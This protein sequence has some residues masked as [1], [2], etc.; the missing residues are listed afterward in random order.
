MD[1][2]PSLVDN[3]T[4]VDGVFFPD[5]SEDQPTP[6][7]A[8]TVPRK[9]LADDKDLVK[10]VTDHL[11]PIFT[12]YENDR[13]ELD[14]IRHVAHWMKACGQDETVR[15]TERT[16]LDRQSS[17]KTKTITQKCGS[18]LFFR[19][20]RSLSA[21]FMSVLMSRRDPYTFRPRYNPEVFFSNEQSDEL[22]AQHNALM[23]WT[24]DQEGFR[25]KAVEFLDQLFTEGAVPVF[26][27]WKR[28][29]AEVLDR[30][31]VRGDDGGVA[32]TKIERLMVVTDYCPE[33]VVVPNECFYADQNIG[34]IQKQPAIFIKS[35]ASLSD[36]QEG[37][38]QKEYLNVDDI[39]V[40]QLYKGDD[41]GIQ[42]DKELAQGYTAAT[43]DTQTGTIIQFDA[44]ARLPIDEKKAKGK[45]WDAKANVGKLYWVTVAGDKWENCVVVRIERNLD[46]DD[47]I[48]C[49][50][51]N[52]LPGSKNKLFHMG[53]AQVVRG[54]FTE[55]TTSKQQAL[56]A[57]TLANNRPLKIRSGVRTQDGTLTFDG[58]QVYHVEDPDDVT[59]FNLAPIPDNMAM[60]GYLE[61][62]SDEAVGNNRVS[63]G[64]PMGARTSSNE[65]EKAYSAAQ[66][67][68]KMLMEY[69]FSQWLTFHAR[70]GVRMWHLY[71]GKDQII[72]ITDMDKVYT[73]VR[74]ID[75]FGDFD[76]EITLV[77]EYERDLL[78]RQNI[79]YSAQNILPM[80]QG[81]VDQ[82]DLAQ[83]IFQSLF[84]IEIKL[85]PDRREESIT[86]ARVENEQL[87]AGQY[88]APTPDEDLNAMLREHV[89][90]RIAWRG[91]DDRAEAEGVRLD[92]LDRHIEETK[93]LLKQ[94]PTAPQGSPEAVPQ[95]QSEG[96]VAGNAIAA[97]RG[98]AAGG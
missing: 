8:E 52:L 62:D 21:Q 39:G 48:P 2:R 42:G 47:E 53:L 20:I 98:A 4:D 50:V 78:T 6:E 41:S 69:V 65:A 88:I 49:R 66:L 26:Y 46:P 18:T 22:A 77:D 79:A 37:Q 93:F 43:D 80:F 25:E 95:N 24:R 81:I 70:K 14:D 51:V 94:S 10:A 55:I 5:T 92:L 54:N 27:R 38:R 76:V 17:D 64:E 91:A 60:L 9:N 16:R 75:L 73:A 68:H 63:R 61:G 34:D 32:G 71:A 84:Q 28:T 59:E 40:A 35:Q 83:K 57:R 96:E 44:I 74:P 36:F 97:V 45:R 19:Q 15:E 29:S 56:D 7:H 33:H 3:S 11:G 1:E 82:R 67:P 87:K 85:L 13:K 12:R 86:R 31:P 23:R 30:W 89:G 58:D 72:K 90:E